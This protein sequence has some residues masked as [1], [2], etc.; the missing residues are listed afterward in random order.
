[1]LNWLFTLSGYAARERGDIVCPGYH[2]TVESLVRDWLNEGWLD[3]QSGNVH[4]SAER[5]IK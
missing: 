5:L 4:W 2:C 1:M 3:D